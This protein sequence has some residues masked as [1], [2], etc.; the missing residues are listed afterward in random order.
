MTFQIKSIG[1]DSIDFEIHYL[2]RGKVI[3]E[4][5]QYISTFS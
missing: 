3:D 2:R 4:I 5:H 1:L